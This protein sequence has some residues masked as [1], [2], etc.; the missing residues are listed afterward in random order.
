MAK[1]SKRARGKS[2]KPKKGKQAP[3]PRGFVWGVSTSAFQIEGAT[4]EDGRG[5][6]IWDSFCAA[7]RAANRD[8]GDPACD[9]YHR[10]AED[11]L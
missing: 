1:Q 11:I 10:Y 9:H 8:T 5:P 7:G 3:W 4:Q 2:A 6:S